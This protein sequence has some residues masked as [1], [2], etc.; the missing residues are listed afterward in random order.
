M[1]IDQNIFIA[2]LI[3]M[4]PQS[5]DFYPNMCKSVI[6]EYNSL[7]RLEHFCQMKSLN[8]RRNETNSNTIDCYINDIPIQ[9][10]FTSSPKSQYN[11]QIRSSKFY[12]NLN[13]KQITGPYS[14]EDPFEYIIVEIGGPK[15]FPEK[16]LG[17]FCIIPKKTLIEQNILYSEK[18]KGKQSFGIYPFDYLNSHWSKKYWVLPNSNMEINSKN[19]FLCI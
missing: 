15:E 18:Y 19:E 1:Y 9:C 4:I 10:K 3:Q 17:H 16:Y 11:Y 14:I 8:F 6:K 12:G 5:I 13:G 2:K 7:Q